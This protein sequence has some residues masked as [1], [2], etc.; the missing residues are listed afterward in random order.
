MRFLQHNKRTIFKC[1]LNVLQ[2]KMFQKCFEKK[3]KKLDICKRI[4]FRFQKHIV[5]AKPKP[6]HEY[7]KWIY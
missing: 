4:F 2:L 5:N 1:F 7:A 3:V 6:L